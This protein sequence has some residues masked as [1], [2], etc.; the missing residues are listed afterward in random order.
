LTQSTLAA[1]LRHRQ[2]LHNK[3]LLL[4]HLVNDSLWL[5]P[6][7]AT[8]WFSSQPEM[9][10]K[11]G[12]RELATYFCQDMEEKLYPASS[13]TARVRGHKKDATVHDLTR[14]IMQG[15]YAWLEEGIVPLLEK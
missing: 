11:P 10:T 5:F 2:S 8:L 4:Q 15:E 12:I 3:Q 13:L 7:A 6:M 9:R 14:K 1:T